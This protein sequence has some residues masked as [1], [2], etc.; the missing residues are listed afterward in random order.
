M[1]KIKNVEFVLIGILVSFGI[2]C[3]GY[4]VGQTMY[5]AKVAINTADV[6][7]LAEKRVQADL[8]Y[9]KVSY[10]VTGKS[11]N[12]IPSLYEES[13]SAQTK[14]IKLLVSNGVKE[15]EIKPGIIDY[16]NEEFRDSSQALVAEK[17]LLI[18]SISVETTNVEL[19]SKVRAK[20]NKL[21]AEG[22]DI[23][24]GAPSYYFTK[25]NAIKP[26]MLKEAT[27]NA[28]LA[29]NEFASNAGVQ[30]GGIRNARQGGFVIRDV[31]ES[32]GDT[33]RIDKEVR[34]VTNITFYL[35]K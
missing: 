9:W 11:K 30:V 29:A 6:K 3:S 10:T 21:I 12:E 8:A 25:L 20:L 24:N 18:G 5:N 1:N 23:T 19:I 26:S 35:T 17:H 34:V 4:F 13:E 31:G 33:K 2:A 16:R 15:S 27:K 22:L 14:V 28:R 32:Y 7:G